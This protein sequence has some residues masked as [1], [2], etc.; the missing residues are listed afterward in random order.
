[1]SKMADL[2]LDIQLMLE[3]GYR[4]VTIASMLGVPVTWVYDVAEK[5]Q[6][7]EGNT[8]VFSPFETINS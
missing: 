2:D 8:E 6:Q 5:Q 7:E 1:M 4:P 3:D